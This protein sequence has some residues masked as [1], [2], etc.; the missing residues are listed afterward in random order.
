MLGRHGLIKLDSGPCSDVAVSFALDRSDDSLELLV[1]ALEFHDLCFISMRDNPK[2]L[3]RSYHV[4]P[5]S[6][7]KRA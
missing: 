5:I 2:N 3:E 6:T 7:T 1:L 4:V